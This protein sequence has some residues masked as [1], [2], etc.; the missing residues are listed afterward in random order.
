MRSSHTS[1]SKH[2]NAHKLEKKPQRSIQQKITYIYMQEK[3]PSIVSHSEEV[4]I[5]FSQ[6]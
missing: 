3:S 5:K 1:V 2:E 6:Q 4:V